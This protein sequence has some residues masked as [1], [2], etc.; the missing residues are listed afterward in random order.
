MM[1]ALTTLC[2]CFFIVGLLAQDRNYNLDFEDGTAGWDLEFRWGGASGYL[3]ALDSVSV[4]AGRYC[5]R[6]QSDP[7]STSRTFGAVEFVLPADFGGDSLELRGWLRT[8]LEDGEETMGGLWLRIDAETGMLAF[9]NMADRPVQGHTPWQEVSIKLPLDEDAHTIHVGGIMLGEGQIYLDDLR[10]F[11]DD[12]PLAEAPPRTLKVFPASLDS[13]FA[14][15]SDLELQGLHDGQLGD[16]AFLARVWGFLKYHHPAIAA[17]EY[18]WDYELFRHL[19]DFLTASRQS[20]AARDAMLVAWIESLGELPP[21]ASCGDE[22]EAIYFQ[23]D[24]SWMDVGSPALQRALQ[25]V[26][27]HR[28]QGKQYYIGM[29]PGIGNPLFLHEEAYPDM[30]FPDDGFRL[31]ALFRYW[32]MIEYFFPYKYYIEREWSEVLTEFLPRFLEAGDALAYRL[33]ALQ[34]IENV[35]DTHANLWGRDSLMRTWKGEWQV[36]VQVKWIEEKLVVTGYY[37]SE[38]GPATGLMPGD[39]ITAINGRPVE[40]MIAEALPFYPASNL[41]TKMRDI[42]KGLLR[43]AEEDW[44]VDVLRGNDRAR[45]SVQALPL[46]AQDFSM[47][48]AY[49]QPDSCYAKLADDVGYINL[50]NIETALLPN[51]FEAFAD[52]RG[53]VIDIRN[54]P[55]EFVVFSL[56]QYLTPSAQAFVRFSFG[57]FDRPGLFMLG[58]PLEVGTENP[59]YYRGK[60][61]VLINEITQSQAEYTTMAFRT[62]PHVTVIGS[63]T[64]GADGNVSRIVLPG[65][66]STM[67]SG[68]GVYYPDGTPTQRVGIVPDETVRPTVAG[69]RAGRDEV[70]ERALEII[71]N[72]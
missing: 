55:N 65:D 33:A 31:L 72:E 67:I 58:E 44:T 37:E 60:V 7:E 54:Y 20:A 53:I 46:E 3:A 12:K 41:P 47:D 6:I 40:E 27:N 68:I 50:G 69:V 17:G 66:L 35:H 61:V 59:D 13:A 9:D 19:P 5:L 42:C 14:G 63:T 36:P 43:G 21:C 57:S 29:A 8:E 18:Q 62:G 51:I 48:W 4:Q 24:Q 38:A 26:F 23:A 39:V 25:R 71:R 10:L 30:A 32:N 2:C 15:G 34:L 52:T 28:S 11:V 56:G 45:R 70:L 22:P 49:V 16:L 64:A 1:R